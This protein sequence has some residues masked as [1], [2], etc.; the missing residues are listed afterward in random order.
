MPAP[1][2]HNEDGTVTITLT[3]DELLAIENW[4]DG[5]AEIEPLDDIEQKTYDR[6]SGL[7]TELEVHLGAKT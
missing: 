4:G 2:K 6:I 5:A 3:M 1:D 7:R